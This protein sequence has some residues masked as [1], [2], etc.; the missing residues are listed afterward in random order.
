MK[1]YIL[2]FALTKGIYSTN[3]EHCGPGFDNMIKVGPY[4][5]YH[6]GQWTQSLEE[7]EAIYNKMKANKIAS[8]E[9]SLAKLHKSTFKIK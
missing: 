6:K 5:Y 7:A 4:S 9:K 2:K 3:A 1:V 8:L